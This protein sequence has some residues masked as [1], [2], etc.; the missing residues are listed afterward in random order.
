MKTYSEVSPNAG[1]ESVDRF[2][3][4]LVAL[5]YRQIPAITKKFR[6]KNIESTTLK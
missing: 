1:Y 4:T 3:I 6:S 5:L 2:I